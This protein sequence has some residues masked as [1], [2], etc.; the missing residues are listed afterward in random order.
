[1]ILCISVVLLVMSLSILILFESSLFFFLV[2]LFKDLSIVLFFLKKR[3]PKNK[4]SSWSS[5]RGS[6]V[7]QSDWEP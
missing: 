2:S 4:N 5:H 7:N 1:M 6:V 3:K